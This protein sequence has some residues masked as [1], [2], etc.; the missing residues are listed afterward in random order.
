MSIQTIYIRR[1]DDPEAAVLLARLRRRGYTALTGLSIERVYRLEG[2]FDLEALLPLLVNPVFENQSPRSRL[3]EREGPIVEIGYR[4]AVTDPETESILCGG[5]ALGQGG[6]LWARVALRYQFRGLTQAEA[7]AA[8]AEE[9]FNPIVQ[10]VIP[11]GRVFDSLRPTGTPD[12]VRRISLAG[13][14]GDELERLARDNSWYAPLSQMRALQEYEASRG[15]PL[16]DAEIEIIVQSWSDHCYHTTWKSLGLLRRLADATARVGHPDVVSVFKDNAGGLALTDDWVVTIKGETHNFPSAIATFGGVATKHGGVIRDSIG[17]GRG[18]Y[19]I[20]GSTVMGTMD[21]RLPVADVPA[22]ALP[23]GHIVRE[24]IRATAYYCNPMGIPMMYSLYRAHPG[25]A[26]CL[27]LGHSVGLIPRKYAQKEPPRPGDIAVL[28][29]GRTGRD[30]LHGAT[31]SSAGMAEETRTREAAAVQIGHPITQ[32]KFMEA[33]PVLRDAGCLRSITDLGAGGLSCAA[34]EMGESTG[35]RLDLDR[36]PLKDASLTAWEILLSESQERMLLAVPP[37][38]LAAA[39]EILARYDV[40]AAQVGEFTATGRYEAAWRGERVVDLEMGFLWGACPIEPA[41]AEEPGRD[42]RPGPAVPPFST[43]PEHACRV[44]AHYHCCDQSAAGFQFDSTVQGRTVIGPYGGVT[45]RMPT[46]A[47]VAAPL[48]GR[49]TRVGVASTVAFN[50]FY[51]EVDPAGLA[52]LAVL[53]AVSRAVAVGADPSAIT[54]CD[55]FYT[56]PA[57]PGINWSLLRMVEAAADLSVALGMPFISGKDSSSGTM[58]R[59]DGGSIDVPLTLVVATLGRVPDVSRCVTKQ[60]RWAGDRLILLGDLWPERLG[61]SVYLDTLGTRGDRLH[62]GG[63]AWAAGRLALWRRLFALYQRPE[64]PILAA[65]AIGEG[66]LLA[67][68]FEMAYGGGLGAELDLDAFAGGRWDGVLF[69]EAVGA[70]LLELAP[71]AEPE[72]L[73]DGLPW[74]GVGRVTGEA[75]LSCRYEGRSIDLP[76]AGLAAA[77]QGTFTEVVS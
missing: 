53:E 10:E 39:L 2:D 6:L 7:E 12:D 1:A 41:L 61:G 33:V 65:A 47:F 54:L 8:A 14:T 40:M 68:A 62:E 69:A 21:P 42:L 57:S 58:R 30:G 50:P 29:G 38:R 76:M 45:G 11:P 51:G 73:F 27:A 17:F 23:P 22:G 20:G 48:R 74:R 9:L 34:G 35:I 46:N 75:R 18:G 32:R 55:N 28:I 66:G 37:D 19:P 60:F 70:F 16:T 59:A 64:R 3:V 56:P 67:R 26:K 44:L 43:L 24:S 5:R 13:L 15:Y 52:R 77:W 31:A 49:D 71:D 72:R 4:R 63:Q 36:V 25:Y